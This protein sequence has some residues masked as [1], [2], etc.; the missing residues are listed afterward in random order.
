MINM[1]VCMVQREIKDIKEVPV[2]YRAKVQEIID[3]LE[4]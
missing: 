1:Y 2:R 4:N 3:Q